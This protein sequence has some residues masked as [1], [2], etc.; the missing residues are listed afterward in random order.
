M[1]EERES[2][3]H[4][5][6]VVISQNGIIK[7]VI[8]NEFLDSSVL[9]P[10]KSLSEVIDEKSLEKYFHFL[11]VLKTERA[12]YDWDINIKQ[13]GKLSS[14]YFV[15]GLVGADFLIVAS[16]SKT[17]ADFYYAEL[18]KMNNEQTNLLR[19]NIKETSDLQYFE[20]LTEL[21]NELAG[22]QRELYK[23]NSQLQNVIKARD[24]YLGMAVHDFRNPLGGINNVC[25]ILLDGDIGPL[26]NEQREFIELV[27]GSS[28]HL[29]DVVNDML[30]FSSIESGKLELNFE[31]T[32]ITGLLRQSVAFNAPYARKKNITLYLSDPNNPGFSVSID[33]KK[34][35]QVLDN[36]ISNAVKFSNRDTAVRVSMAL[37]EDRP[38]DT[39]QQPE[40][41]PQKQ[42]LR[43]SVRDEGQGIAQEELQYLFNPFERLG[44]TATEGEKSSGLGLAI[45]K[46]IVEGHG[47]RIWVES[48]K[49]KGSVFSFTLPVY[50]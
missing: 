50:L 24:K 37:P 9:T 40:E 32:D 20:E 26:N 19:G 31:Y 22:L 11:T 3:F 47:G 34:I 5:F 21:N 12:L 49:G 30:D 16:V 28:E 13:N 46:K 38:P 35:M 25:S 7:E 44:V 4:G 15:G 42:V 14:L 29:L 18:M 41:G 2:N 17:Q 33:K 48:S 45:C 1:T 23:K 36:L 8:R 6:A 39:Q 43:I 10:G 27:R